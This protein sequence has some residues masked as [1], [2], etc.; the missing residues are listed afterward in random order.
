MD[1]AKKSKLM[2]I[3]QDVAAIWGA[4]CVDVVVYPEEK[5]VWFECNE[6]GEPYST[7]MSFEEIKEDYNY[8]ITE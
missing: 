7:S 1:E 2:E 8:D 4:V 5:V 6:R 3:G